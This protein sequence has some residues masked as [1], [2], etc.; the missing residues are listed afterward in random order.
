MVKITL[1]FL[2][3]DISRIDEDGIFD[4]PEATIQKI[5]VTYDLTHESKI[6]DFV[7]AFKKI[8]EMAGYGGVQHYMDPYGCI[9]CE[10]DYNSYDDAEED[11]FTDEEI[12][13]EPTTEKNKNEE[14]NN[15]DQIDERTDIQR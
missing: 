15:V 12:E 10:D 2:D 1:E 6:G 4:D 14:Q 5:E 7:S 3:D 11:F 9:E 8:L 13:I